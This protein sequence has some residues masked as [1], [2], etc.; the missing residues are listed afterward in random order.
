MAK[1]PFTPPAPSLI[2]RADPLVQKAFQDQAAQIQGLSAQ[3][4]ALPPPPPVDYAKIAQ[5]L[6]ISGSNP[7]N[8][9]SLIGKLSTP[10]QAAIVNNSK[11][12]TSGQL[13]QPGTISLI[14]GVLNYFSNATNPGT[15]VPVSALAFI[16]QDTH[17]NR[18][19]LAAYNPT[20]LPTGSMFWETDRTLLYIVQGTF[21]SGHWEYALGTYS[22]NQSAVAGVVAGLTSF[23]TNLLLNV[24]D[25]DHILAWN[26]TNLLWGPGEQGSGAGP[27]P[28]EIDPT[29]VGWHLY[30]GTAN[31]PYLKS[32]GSLGTVTLP[33]LSG[34]SPTGAYIKTGATNNGPNAATAPTFSGGGLTLSTETATHNH[35]AA[36]ESVS[37]THTFGST[38][39]AQPY[40]TGTPVVVPITLSTES[41]LHTHV[42]GNESALHTHTVTGSGGVGTNGEPENIV[43][44]VWF[45]Q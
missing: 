8:V 12:P 38:Q 19:A 14:N 32:D 9:N 15:W 29:G 33:N 45:R 18:I 30:D 40:L 27:L 39:N 3:I 4:K 44:R 36:T 28:F 31:V 23:D 17:A 25:Y 21:G 24:A 43:R 22:L 7:L 11:A 10:Q 1:L 2:G 20:K 42:L 5:A 41:A 16:F 13:A 34:T 35:V 26:G 37:H 6:S